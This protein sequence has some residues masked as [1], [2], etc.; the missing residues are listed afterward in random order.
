[1]K[2]ISSYFTCVFIVINLFLASCSNLDN[3]GTTAPQDSAP[4]QKKSKDKSSVSYCQALV[5]PDQALELSQVVVDAF[6]QT[7]DHL[8]GF[9][10]AEVDKMGVRPNV[11]FAPAL[12]RL[13]YADTG[14][15]KFHAT[16]CTSLGMW[17]KCTDENLKTL[18]GAV[19]KSEKAVNK[20]ADYYKPI[21]AK[22]FAFKMPREF[23]PEFFAIPLEPHRVYDHK[24]QEISDDL[25][26]SVVKIEKITDTTDQQSED[27]RDRFKNALEA[28]FADYS[29]KNP[30]IALDKVLCFP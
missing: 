5:V 28:G 14:K 26:V 19:A 7:M 1:M 12:P 20:Y 15:S 25:H 27:L 18:V 24:G 17:Y 21:V 3:L 13:Y 4:S 16:L 2:K 30:K 8:P 11:S 6:N 10:P 23:G 22:D 9:V 29:K